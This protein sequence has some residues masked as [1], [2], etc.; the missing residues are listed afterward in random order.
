[1]PSTKNIKKDNMQKTIPTIVF[2]VFLFLSF[3]LLTTDFLIKF[4]AFS[5]SLFKTY[6][7]IVSPAKLIELKE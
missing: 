1:M 4:T 5:K 3:G 2:S 7:S 6:N